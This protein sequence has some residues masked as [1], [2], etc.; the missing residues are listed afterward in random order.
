MSREYNKISDTLDLYSVEANLQN[1]YS[2]FSKL[3][4]MSTYVGTKNYYT[5]QGVCEVNGKKFITEYKKGEK[6]KILQVDSFGNRKEIILDLPN[7]THVGGISHM[8]GNF[9]VCSSNGFVAIFDYN[10]INDIVRPNYTFKT[11][12]DN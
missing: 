10:T 11:G 12:L 3:S 5:P 4:S 6:S 7:G 2:L 1:E 9:Y 8:N